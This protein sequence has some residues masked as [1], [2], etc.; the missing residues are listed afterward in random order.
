MSNA[1]SVFRNHRGHGIFNNK[2]GDCYMKRIIFGLIIFFCFNSFFALIE[3]ST[4]GEQEKD[5]KVKSN[6]NSTMEQIAK[7]L[8]FLGYKIETKV[9]SGGK[10]YFIAY[11]STANDIVVTPYEPNFTF[12]QTTLTSVKSPSSDMDAF[13]NKANGSFYIARFYYETNEKIKG[14]MLR[15]DAIYTGEYSKESF[16]KFIDMFRHDQDMIRSM[17]NYNKIFLED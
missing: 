10:P 8:E 1:M 9:D 15:F 5:V 14:T 16:G 4:A 7:H 17:G 13:V 2:K 12:F 6:M 3:V 11:N